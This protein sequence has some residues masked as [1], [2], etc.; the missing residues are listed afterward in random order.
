MAVA[1]W[2]KE[3]P[4]LT[5][6]QQAI[7]R[8]WNAD[9]LGS[10]KPGRFGW[11]SRFD[12]VFAMRSAG[13]GLR[14]LEIGAGTGTHL[15]YEPLGDYVALDGSEDLASRIPLRP[16]LEVVV[17]DCERPL[18]YEANYFDRVLAIHIL[19]HL[20]DL[21]TTLEEV[22][23]VLRPDGVFSVVIPC[24]GGRGYTVG[25]WITT[26]RMFER[27]YK[28]PYRWLIGYDHCN[29]AREVMAE[30]NR[31]FRLRRRTFWPLRAPSVD[32]NLTVG[33]E[34]VHR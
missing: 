3:R 32:I 22:A 1:Q 5:D 4:V 14:T 26:K 7:Y 27:R 34:L 10:L 2:P 16:G 17:A 25:Q 23:R 12:H 18:P 20:Y 19:E 9:F 15:P 29:T 33:L 8:D 13:S 11:I 30:L 28:T 6:A 24:Q 21:P 31:H